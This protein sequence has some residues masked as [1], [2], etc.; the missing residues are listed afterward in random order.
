MII[1]RICME[2]SCKKP[3]TISEEEGKWLIEKGFVLFKRCP[4]C[5]KKRR[6]EKKLQIDKTLEETRKQMKNLGTIDDLI[7]E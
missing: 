7:N 6:E 1:S 2:E 5:R 3:F 4:D